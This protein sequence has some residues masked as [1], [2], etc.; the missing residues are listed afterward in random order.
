MHSGYDALPSGIFRRFLVDD[1]FVAVFGQP[2]QEAGKNLRD[3]GTI[4]PR[5]DGCG[6][7]G[8]CLRRRHGERKIVQKFKDL[9][10]E[11]TGGHRELKHAVQQE[12]VIAFGAKDRRLDGLGLDRA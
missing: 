11:D 4:R 2:G 8:G 1:H 7:R 5:N 10:T 6:F 3:L 9:T 12:F